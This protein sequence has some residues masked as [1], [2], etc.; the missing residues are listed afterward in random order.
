MLNE[1]SAPESSCP[2]PAQFTCVG[3]E[4]AIILYWTLN[5]DRISTYIYTVDHEFPR[6]LPLMN[7]SLP[8]EIQVVNASQS[9]LNINIISTLSVSN[10]LFLNGSSLK[11]QDE[12]NRNSN[13]I[14]IIIKG[15][16]SNTRCFPGS[17]YFGE[18]G[19]HCLHMCKFS[20]IVALCAARCFVGM[21]L[22]LTTNKSV[23]PTLLP[24]AA[25]AQR[26]VK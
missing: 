3:T 15:M 7:T 25:H 18:P 20:A 5:G 17:N 2:G 24:H 8:I 22:K 16:L 21:M 13:V 9:G 10:V 12:G 1:S 26:G 4:T 19:C 14:H 11:C 23:S 6:N